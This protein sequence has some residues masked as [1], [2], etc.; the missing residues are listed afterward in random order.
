MGIPLSAFQ[1]GDLFIEY[2]FEEVL[3]RY[4][5]GTGRFFCKRYGYS[6]EHEVPSDFT[7][8]S[9]ARSAGVLTTAE[10]Y[11]SEGV[12]TGEPADDFG[13]MAVKH[14]RIRPWW[15]SVVYRRDHTRSGTIEVGTDGI[16]LMI[17]ATDSIKELLDQVVWGINSQSCL[18]VTYRDEAPITVD[19]NSKDYDF[20]LRLELMKWDL[21]V[22]GESSYHDGRSST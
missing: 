8:L 19:K 15:L 9:E 5:K 12:S 3:F 2:E 16:L 4:E 13:R 22:F 10:R 7:F 6:G 21:N 18:H 1:A 17:K 20:A 14:Q 11:S